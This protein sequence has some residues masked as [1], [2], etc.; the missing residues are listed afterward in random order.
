LECLNDSVEVA[1]DETNSENH[2]MIKTTDTETHTI[3]VLKVTYMKMSS[4]GTIS[5]SNL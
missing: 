4:S 5:Q 3:S 1:M 2:S